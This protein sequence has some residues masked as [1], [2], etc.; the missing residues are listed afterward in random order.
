MGIVYKATSGGREVV[1]K[2]LYVDD[3][4]LLAD[5]QR[6]FRRE[7]DILSAISHPAF[8]ACYGYFTDPALTR[9]F[10]A[11]EFIPGQDLEHVLAGYV[12]RRMGEIEV[13]QYGVQV[14]DA[15][16]VMHNHVDSAGNPDPLVHRDIKPANIILRPS[17]QICVLDL[18]IAR[19]VAQ[20]AGTQVRATRAGTSEYCSLQQITGMG[21]SVRDDIYALAATLFH[22]V[23]GNP[24]AGDHTQRAAEIDALPQAWQPI[25]RRAIQN[26]STLRQRSVA[27]FKNDLIGLLPPQLQPQLAPATP[28]AVPAA[29]S[30]TIDWRPSQ[31]AMINPGEYRKVLAGRVMQGLLGVPGV[32]VIPFITDAGGVGLLGTPG[33]TVTTGAHGD[34][35]LNVTDI[36][37]PVAVTRRDIEVVVEDPN[38]GSELLRA[39]TAIRR[40]WAWNRMKAKGVGAAQAAGAGLAHVGAGAA[41]QAARPFRAV[42]NAVANFVRSADKVKITLASLI[43]LILATLILATVQRWWHGAVWFWPHT[44]LVGICLLYLW[45]Q[46]RHN[47]DL[48]PAL[49]RAFI[50]PLTIIWVMGWVGFLLR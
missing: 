11:M 4:A 14:C 43:I 18:G 9:E 31:T 8:P 49:R 44:M 12:A 29:V 16:A 10:M 32:S 6:R 42:G 37:V 36:T 28:V 41:H 23:T 24:F 30:V 25:F 48:G 45:R 17:G 1:V 35:S 27:E 46:L 38:T 39:T 15:L 3:P 33:T 13:L 50:N 7:A 19:Q 34:F 47:R 2:E 20:S 40:P 5:A 21:M 26:D 22:L